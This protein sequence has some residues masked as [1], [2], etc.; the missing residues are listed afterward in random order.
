MKSSIYRI[1]FSEYNTMI[2]YDHRPFCYNISFMVPQ[3]VQY[4][5]QPFCYYFTKIHTVHYYVQYFLQVHNTLQVHTDICI[6]QFDSHYV[7]F[8]PL[9]ITGSK[10]TP[11]CYF[12]FFLTSLDSF[13]I[14]LKYLKAKPTKSTHK[15]EFYSLLMFLTN[16]LLF[17]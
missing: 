1:K 17:F 12:L 6:Q 10:P 2:Q 11:R 5:L 15:Y 7:L 14:P 8:S 16:Y 9:T 3:T 4:G 13:P